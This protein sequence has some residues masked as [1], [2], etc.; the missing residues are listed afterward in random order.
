LSWRLRR[1]SRLCP[2]WIAVVCF[3]TPWTFGLGGYAANCQ[4]S[5]ASG[6]NSLAGGDQQ[7]LAWEGKSVLRI[8][9][10]GVRA[11]RLASLT[12]Q[13]AQQPNAP[14]KPENVRSSLRRLYA[15]GLYDTISVSGSLEANG[16]VLSFHGT[17][18]TFIGV[19]SITGAKGANTNSLLERISRLTPGTRF[20]SSSL[21]QAEAAMKRSMAEG[22]FHE[23]KFTYKLTPHP[24][25]QLVDIAYTVNSGPQARVG[26]TAVKGESGLTA[27]EF[28]HYSK[29]KPGHTVQRETPG[30]ALD[31]VENY[32]RKQER[33]E[34]EVR[35]ESQDYDQPKKQVDFDFAANRGP[36]VHVEVDG[37]KLSQGKI[38]KLLPIYEEGS[39]DDD[40]LNE[41]N[42]RLVNYYQRLG[43]FDVK[44]QHEQK[45]G[46]PELVEIVFH[47]TL[48]ARHRVGK[49]R[50]VGAKYFDLPTLEERLSVR[51]RDAF[52]R[53]GIY[54]QSLVAQD[55]GSLDAI[56]QNN[57]FAHVK[58]TPETQDEDGQGGK[59]SAAGGRQGSSPSLAPGQVPG[60]APDQAPGQVPGQIP[61]QGKLSGK[62]KQIGL[63][64]TYH[65]EEGEQSRVHSVQLVGTD[66]V[67]P[68]KLLGMM[69]TS[70]GQPLSPEGLAGDRDA[71]VTYYLSR[72]FDQVQV[73]VTQAEF[74][75]PATAVENANAAEGKT[76]KADKSDKTEK[77]GTKKAK[78]GAKQEE[79]AD[80]GQ[81]DVI[82]H[83]REGEQV[84][85]RRVLITGLHYTRPAT[86]ARGI[87]MKEGQPLDQT[88]LLDTQRNL[89]D[90]A[91]F[92]EVNPVIQN[93]TGEEPQ[94]TVLLQT[95][96]ARRWDVN[97]GAGFELQT[98]TV[99]GSNNSNPNGTVGASPRV[100]LQVSR[101]NLFGRDQTASLRGNY[102]LLEQRI[103]LV[104]QYPHLF[105]NRNLSFSF[106]GGYNNS[107]DVVTYSASK[108]EGS[109]RLTEHFYGEHELLSKANTFIYQFVYR[110]VKVDANSIQ[111]P[112][113]EIP[114]L[115]EAVRVGGPSFTWI[116]DTRDAPLDAHQGTY[117]SFQEFISSA[118]FDSEANFNQVDVSNSSYYQFDRGRFVVARNTRYGQERAYGAAAAEAIPL[119]ERL[120]GG[121]GNS[122][123]GFGINSAGPRDPQSGFPIGGAGAFVN[124]TEL[125]MPP[126]TL[127]Y[128]GSAVSFVLF[129]DM[130]NVFTNASD[131]WPS[132]ARFRQQNREGCRNLTP[133]A[134]TGTVTSTGTLG[135]CSFNYFS[136]ALGV[137]A[138][139]HTPVGPVRVDFSWN[140]NPPIYPV[141][142]N[143][144]SNTNLTKPYVGEG[145]H[146]NFFFSLG[147]SF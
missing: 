20:T 145:S 34:A 54:N 101:I 100:L 144:V 116:R 114:L 37:V 44:A 27:E 88:A 36:V 29:L 70:A 122:H 52:D 17:P 48:G 84:F 55:V 51:A 49:V 94:K 105:G 19:V 41:G 124:S 125:R 40:L 35:L 147:Q 1:L 141:T 66:K 53:Q 143:A 3:S 6:P 45:S 58:V 2:L 12:S 108:L 120:Y 61:G 85:L 50:I 11:A 99:N 67:T 26:T 86:I 118:I 9:F 42:R 46:T 77:A 136:H 82:F 129:H 119:P 63:T 81:V 57:G 79:S 28:R 109:L 7:L 138:R 106:T 104:Y 128:V 69:N 130:G 32:Y 5:V 10:E 132:F 59:G 62:A 18:R 127:P 16:V 21:T 139:Y 13:L 47:V 23:P 33:L 68:D 83:I 60:Q 14:L 22:G 91:L 24:E 65:I 131:I 126:P 97:Y 95:T 96:E 64:V 107:Q 102:G 56:Y 73:E 8:D 89:Y 115:L 113:D 30:K 140:L 142:Y 43:Y 146:F 39:V 75:G 123:R 111:V 134:P 74:T 31:G 80:Q 72:G 110:R 92:N 112:A 87:T 76:E 93:P 15:T 78:P 133:G 4:E 90:L 135:T 71:L 38:R 98:G 117:T 121:G 103:N 137:G 25:E